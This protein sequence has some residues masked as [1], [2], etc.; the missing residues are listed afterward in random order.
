MLPVTDKKARLAIPVN[1]L[2]QSYAG[3]VV[4]VPMKGEGPL[5][6]A[7]RVPVN[8]LFQDEEF[9]Y[10]EAEGLKEGD[11]AV[12]EG[13]ERLIPFQPLIIATR[14]SAQPARPAP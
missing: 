12:V 10:L 14:E 7:K 9:V 3:P 8:V 11:Q 1:A 6:L 2:K 13:N 5:P 4:F